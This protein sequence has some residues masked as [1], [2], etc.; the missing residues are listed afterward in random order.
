MGHRLGSEARYE[1]AEQ[2]FLLALSIA[3]EERG[4]PS[5]LPTSLYYMGDLY[6][7]YPMLSNSANATALLEESLTRFEALLGTEHPIN[8]FVLDRLGSIAYDEG[9]PERAAELFARADRIVE[10]GFPPDHPFRR[11]RERGVRMEYGYHPDEF[12]SLSKRAAPTGSTEALQAAPTGPAG[13]LP[14]AELPS[15]NATYL[16]PNIRLPDGNLGYAHVTPQDMPLRV[17]IAKPQRPPMYASTRQAREVAI[18][19]MRMWETAIRPRVPWFELEFV[20][21]DPDAAVQVEWKRR[22]TGPFAGF[23]RLEYRQVAGRPWVGGSMEIATAPSQFNTLSIDE[24]RLL[25]A[26]EFGHVLGLRHC[27]ECDSAM[28][29][30][31]ATRDRILVTDLDARTF[32]E[33]VEIPIG[34]PAR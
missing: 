20:E 12:V 17:S 3:R 28:N 30:S 34:T 22:I 5:W 13:G 11:A 9:D 33:L 26:H 1:E 10:S 14:E 19:A 16:Q 2:H 21:D 24:V 23:G 8:A 31:W 7:T 18:E 15:G 25:V 27:L 32:A 29:Y 4:D 6:Y